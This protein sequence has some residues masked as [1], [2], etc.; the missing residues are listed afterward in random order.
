[1]LCRTCG[2]FGHYLEGCPEKKESNINT[3]VNDQAQMVVN[4]GAPSSNNVDKN[5]GDGPWVVVQKPRRPR[6]T[7]EGTRKDPEFEAPNNME[8]NS[9]NPP[10]T[11]IPIQAHE[12]R[13]GKHAK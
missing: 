4:G 6:Q 12:R 10:M 8:R 13:R 1:M 11:S 3:T 7:K 9:S 2:K 5:S